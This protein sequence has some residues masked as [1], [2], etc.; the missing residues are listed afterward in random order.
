MLVSSLPLLELS[1]GTGITQQSTSDSAG[2]DGEPN[3]LASS[4]AAQTHSLHLDSR[5]SA[6]TGENALYVGGDIVTV[7]TLPFYLNDYTNEQRMQQELK[8]QTMPTAE[9]FLGNRSTWQKMA[10]GARERLI[11]RLAI[12]MHINNSFACT[13]SDDEEGCPEKVCSALRVPG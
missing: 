3:S 10:R 13:K 12:S 9:M 5:I 11:R 2:E 8:L 7:S 4:P 1:L 6:R